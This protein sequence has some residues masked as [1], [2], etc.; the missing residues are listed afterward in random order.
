MILNTRDPPDT[1]THMRRIVAPFTPTDQ[2]RLKDRLY[3]DTKQDIA[4][5]ADNIRNLKKGKRSAKTDR[6][7][8]VSDIAIAIDKVL[9]TALASTMDEVWEPSTTITEP[10]SQQTQ[11]QTPTGGTSRTIKQGHP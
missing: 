6:D 11:A 2:E 3:T 7:T 5:I 9:Q 10:R 8:Q 1:H 4:V